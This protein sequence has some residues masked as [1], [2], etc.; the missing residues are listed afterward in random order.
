MRKLRVGTRGSKL[1]LAQTETVVKL[2]SSR[3][4]DVFFEI[5]V[6]RSKGDLVPDR[7]LQ[8]IDGSGLFTG[9]IEA[10]LG[11]GE[12]D[13]AVHSMKD[14]PAETAS[15]L[16][17]A[18]APVRADMR[19]VLILCEGVTCL[20][21]LQDG[22]KIGT[23]SVRRSIQLKVM[24]PEIE[25]VPI[26][27]NVDSR[28][29]KVGTQLDGVVLA[30]AGLARLGL[31]GLVT[32]YLEP[33][34]M[35]PAPCQGVLALELRKEDTFVMNILETIR[36]EKTDISARAERAF[37]RGSGAGCH[38][39][40]GAFCEHEASGEIMLTGLFGSEEKG[41]VRGSISGAADDAE[42]VGLRL[43]QQLL[44]QFEEL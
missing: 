43:A 17:L 31:S 12:I 38:A 29:T 44:R 11:R 16:T 40:V 1:A 27:G 37:L 2:L 5:V 42:L 6:I 30:A 32:Q 24:K 22:A 4:P 25:I 14:L 39:P 19:D 34:E 33:S 35:I 10:A 7:P 23:G 8:E 36:D 15:G 3:F 18:P 28:I 26:R 9:E 13:F 21:G 20:S 41:V